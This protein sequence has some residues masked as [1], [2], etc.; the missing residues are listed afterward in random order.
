M[1]NRSTANPR[2][3]LIVNADD[4]G[5]SRGVNQG[6]FEAHEYGIVT[7]AS[8][9]VRWPAVKEAIEQSKRFPELCLGL[10]VDLGEWA[11]RNGEWQ[12]L[13][14]VLSLPTESTIEAEVYR[15]LELFRSLTGCDPTHLDSHQHI[16]HEEPLLTILTDLARELSI[17]LRSFSREIRYCGEFYGQTNKGESLPEKLTPEALIRVL[18][19]L[20]VGITELGCHP[21]LDQ[22]LDTMYRAERFIEVKTLCE[23][24]VRAAIERLDIELHSFVGCEGSV[25]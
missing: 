17:P 2:K 23:P 25:E 18:E 21:G 22:D 7:A 9:L 4:L 1:A 11:Y 20:P 10:H 13:Y 8:T 15:Q 6:I 14:E 12:A 19:Q 5:M 3:S 16:H 24:S